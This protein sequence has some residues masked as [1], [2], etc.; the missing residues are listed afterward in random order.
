M[1][2]IIIDTLEKAQLLFPELRP[3][4]KGDYFLLYCPEC[5][6]KEAFLYKKGSA[7]TCNR[8]DK[9]GYRISVYDYLK[10]NKRLSLT[11]ITLTE[12]Q[13][14][15]YSEEKTPDRQLILPGSIKFFSEASGVVC[16]KFKN[17]L[18]N[19]KI[20]NKFIDELGYVFGSGDKFDNSIFVPFYENRSINYF[21]CR[22]MSGELRYLNSDVSATDKVFNLDNI[23][24]GKDV[25]IFEGVFDAMSINE[26][27]ISTAMLTN[28]FSKEKINKILD[29]APSNII[30][31]PD[32]DFAGVCA[33]E[34]NLRRI[35]MLIPPSLDIGI[36]IY[37]IDKENF[38]KLYAIARSSNSTQ[39]KIELGKRI[40]PKNKDFND[41]VKS[42]NSNIIK[43]E[44]C[45]KWSPSEMDDLVLSLW[46]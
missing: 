6:H 24:E 31:V 27:Q 21:I 15:S 40:V 44:D 11:E 7:I 4:D 19:R 30:M 5:G 9:C 18:K 46:I 17:Y 25:F 42:G 23:Q 34:K 29:K 16:D 36:Y 26:N 13:K 45:I 28:N 43:L 14:S 2:K 12:A 3:E 20:N 35:S 22:R 32:I 41:F 38:S 10:N 1:A 33:L 39:K 37:I 8:R